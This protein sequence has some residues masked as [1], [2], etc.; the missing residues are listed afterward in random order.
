MPLLRRFLL[1]ASV[2][3]GS[4]LLAGPALATAPDPA[5][6]STL[7]TTHFLVHYSSD[8]GQHFSM[9]T[10]RAG[11]IGALAEEALAAEL[12]DGYPM[13]PSDGVSGGD[14]RMD[15]Y[16]QSLGAALGESDAYSGGAGASGYILLDA[17]REDEL[18]RSPT[19]SFT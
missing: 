14:G 1:L 18:T 3:A 7:G 4:A 8:S 17:D 9:T 5:A 12:A 13:P 19:R 11:D 2:V 10:A 16:V 15:I 6:T